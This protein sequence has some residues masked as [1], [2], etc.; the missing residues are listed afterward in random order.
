[1]KNKQTNK[2]TEKIKTIK[3]SLEAWQGL[4]NV[5]GELNAQTYDQVILYLLKK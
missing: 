3:I 5:K 4:T 1:M 2:T